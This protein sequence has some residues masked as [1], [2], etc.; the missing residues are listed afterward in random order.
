[1]GRTD[2]NQVCK[3]E[4][5]SS[6]GMQ[7]RCVVGGVLFHACMKVGGVPGKKDSTYGEIHVIEYHGMN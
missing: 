5:M 3:S 4:E 2:G 6:E 7:E 1:M